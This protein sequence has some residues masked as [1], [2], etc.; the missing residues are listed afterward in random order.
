MTAITQPR[1][2]QRRK[3]VSASRTVVNVAMIVGS[4]VMAYPLI[5]GLAATFTTVEGFAKSTFWPLI[6]APTLSNWEAI[7][8]LPP[9]VAIW[10]FN[11]VLRI[12]WYILVP[13]IVAV[14]CGYVFARLRF[15]GRIL[16]FNI[17]LS[18]MMFPGI[19]FLIPTY[20]L[21]ARVPF[22]GG[23][24]ATGQGGHGLINSFA[25][26]MIAGLCNATYIF[27]VRQAIISIPPDF[28]EAA[29]LDGAGLI[30]VLWHVYL[31]LLRPVIIVMAIFQSVAIWND[32]MWPLIT[33]SGN[34]EAWT[35]GLGGQN[36]MSD[37]ATLKAATSNQS[38]LSDV[39][40]AFTVA[41][42]AMLPPIILFFFLQRHF[43][44]GMQGF[45]LKG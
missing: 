22:L 5:F 4:L 20:V 3:K 14:L 34:A 35:I 39:P 40:M 12:A 11:T 27:L 29:R 21:M 2:K 26:L 33:V 6:T 41:N 37:M 16:A 25:A 23:N 7:A 45:S 17:L 8:Q 10:F 36:L 30:R 19:V 44:K 9:T 28:E 38:V 31:P 42:L 13:G 15:R 32:Y 43:V 24:D 18:G 1:R